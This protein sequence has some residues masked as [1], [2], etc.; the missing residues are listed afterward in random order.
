MH[1]YP[2]PRFLVHAHV[3]D[4][5]SGPNFKPGGKIISALGHLCGVPLRDF[6][7]QDAVVL[8]REIF[9]AVVVG[10]G[11]VPH[12]TGPNQGLLG[13]GR[14]DVLLPCCVEL[15]LFGKLRRP[16]VVR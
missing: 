11:A 9:V 6:F 3:P 12:C 15:S 13:H 8:D 5:S 1:A 14:E 16:V 4:L 7:V 10:A 2:S